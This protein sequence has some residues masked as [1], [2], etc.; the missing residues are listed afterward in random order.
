MIPLGQE[1]RLGHKTFILFLSKKTT[2]S[3]V[4]LCVA[5]ILGM[6]KD[7]VAQ[8]L[9]SFMKLAGTVNP[10]AIQAISDATS[11]FALALLLISIIMFIVGY[12]I[13][14]IHYNN[15]TFTLEEFD[16]KLKRGLF[17]VKEISL[18][19]RQI[20]SV[21]ITRTLFHQFFG[22]CRLVMITA[23]HED[24]KEHDETDTVFD[25]I[26]TDL[27]EEVR[28]FL[29][30]KIGIQIVETERSHETDVNSAPDNA[31]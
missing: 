9:V 23:G 12:I 8:G 10:G 24:E 25:P 3:L 15:Y 6:S 5:V 2:T 22:V 26:D 29:Q 16:L 31:K 14:K 27:A 21:D 7:I 30:R 4:L 1:Q 17:N 18:P 20:Q 19:Y 13:S 28:L 11:G